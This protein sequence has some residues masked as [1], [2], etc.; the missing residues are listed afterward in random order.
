MA[1]VTALTGRD[2]F[3]R[4]TAERQRLRDDARALGIL[5]DP[6]SPRTVA[7][8][9]DLVAS[10]RV[11]VHYRPELRFAGCSPCECGGNPACPRCNP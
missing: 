10:R 2:Y 5:D 6:D 3:A 11:D 9:R 1:Q 7:E 4:R 8:L